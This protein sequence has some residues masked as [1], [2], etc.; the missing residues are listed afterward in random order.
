MSRNTQFIGKYRG[1]VSDNQ[2]P[3]G[4]GRLRVSVPDV[5]GTED[6]GWAMPAF[7]YAGPQV[8]LYLIPPTGA[9]VW[10]EFEHGDSEYPI[11]TGCFWGSRLEVPMAASG[12][13]KKVLKTD[14]VTITIDDA[15]GSG[16]ITIETITGMKIVM[17]T[18]AIELT[19]GQG[20]SVKLTAATVSV[21]SGA[22]EVM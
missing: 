2:D 10:V 12:P 13:D 11:W 20:A 7:P 5:Y 14:N 9:L 3:N 17:D 1:T 21:N 15:T 4:Q 19:T 6:S 18:T 16:G 8:G 22:L